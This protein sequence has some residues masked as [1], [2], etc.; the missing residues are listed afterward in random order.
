M[1]L[2]AHA[3]G[4]LLSRRF[5]NVVVHAPS[6]VPAVD[7]PLLYDESEIMS[8]HT[9]LVPDHV[10]L[11]ETC[12]LHDVV[13]VCTGEETAEA[14][15]AA[16][17]PTVHVRDTVTL[18]HLYNGMQSEYVSHER[19]DARLRAY[20]DTYAGFPALLDACARAM[21]CDCALVD[22]RFRMVAQAD[23]LTGSASLWT[24][25]RFDEGDI[26]LFMASREYRRMRSTRRIFAVPGSTG[27]FMKNVFAGDELV[28]SLVIAHEAT[29]AS[30][31]YTRFLLGYL[32]PFVEEMYAHLGSFDLVSEGAT[33]IRSM[34]M[35]AFAGET[36]DFTMLDQ[37]LAARP[38]DEGVGAQ[39]GGSYV[40]VRLER[41]F[42]HEGV[43]DIGYLSRRIE[44][45]WPHVYDIVA[46][47][48][49]FA[50]VDVDMIA[51]ETSSGYE[52]EFARFARETL[53]KMGMSRLFSSCSELLAARMQA[54][55]ALEQGKVAQPTYWL[56]RFDDYALDGLIAHGQGSLPAGYVAHPALEAL[57]RYDA[58]RDAGLVEALRTFM[59]CRYNATEAAARLFVA[60]STLLNRLARIEELTGIDLDSWEERLYLGI[61]LRLLS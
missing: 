18:Q 48:A 58:E 22:R 9:V 6:R 43:D 39:R 5:E 4:Y 15:V 55:A 1:K 53:V 50:F 54:S 14:A 33:R 40:V 38:V 41:S 30:A 28:G 32:A 17:F 45:A 34:L 51:R 16:G 31:R 61:S 11:D 3:I 37:M 7:Y 44:L 52:Q 10:L 24:E 35:R 25:G 26:D 20:V 36:R 59:E 23:A 46:D 47:G 8:G 49:L 42:T 60:R 19:L 57:A 12:G 56:Y 13:C 21:G 29:V 27:L 2:D